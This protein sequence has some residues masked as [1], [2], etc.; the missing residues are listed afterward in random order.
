ME[1]MFWFYLSVK[2]CHRK[3]K[4]RGGVVMV[5][6]M[7]INLIAKKKSLLLI[8]LKDT[9][10]YFCPSRWLTCHKSCVVPQQIKK[11]IDVL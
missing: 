10:K 8:K 6:G 5:I 3:S 4:K 2:L 1:M 11:N 9:I 7:F